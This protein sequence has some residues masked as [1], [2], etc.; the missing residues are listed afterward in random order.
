MRNIIVGTAG[1]IDH[2]KTALVRALTGEDTD[3]LAEEKRRGISIDLGFA[4]LDL[5]PDLR[6]GFVDVP[7]HERFVKNMLAGA[8][9]IDA[10][11]LVV[12]AEESI[13]PQTRE[14]FDICRLLG[15]ERGLI[16]LTKVDLAEPEMV[17]LVRLEV[18][19]FVQG[20]FLEGSPIVGVS[21]RTGEGLGDL[22]AALE[23]TAE[24]VREKDSGRHLRLPVDR[25]FVMRGFGRVVTGT[26]YSGEVRVE[27][28]LE[29]HPLGVTVRVRGIQVHGAAVDRAAAGQRTA[30]NLAGPA[31]DRV[32][33]GM[34]LTHPGRFHPSR[35]LEGRFSLLA[36]ASP[37]RHRAPI[38]L[39]LGSSEVI[40]EVRLLEPA[41]EIPPGG[42]GWVRLLLRQPL[43]VLPGDRFIARMFS[44]VTTIGGGTVLEIEPPART[45]RAQ[46]ARRL[47]TIERGSRT[48][49]VALLVKET[50]YGMGVGAL[51]RRTG[52]LIEEIRASARDERLVFFEDLA[53]W[54]ADRDSFREHA[55]RLRNALQ[56]YHDAYPLK[57]G[58]P[59]EELR[60]R[61]LAAAPA[62]Y[63]DALLQ[64]TPELV[65]DG[66]VIRLAAH[67]LSLR[68]EEETAI[69]EM[70]E[71]F[72]GAGLAVPAI[73]EVLARCGVDPR[74]AKNLL[75][76]LLRQGNLV[77]VNDELVYHQVAIEELRRLLAHHRGER[78][79]VGQF[80]DWTGVSRKYA[81]PLLEFLD[82][83]RVTRRDGDERIVL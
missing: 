34:T 45:R 26:L 7:G 75:D 29:V 66:E 47:E 57:P 70:E 46:A 41:E 44:P 83:Q 50:E 17:H 20:S 49:W 32:E 14:H 35:T 63:M 79:K 21:A 24:T 54:I 33:R 67:R 22:R 37:L 52:L 65:A 58:M 53:P 25:S 38:H 12:S 64:R 82:R 23:A 74:R 51:V 15:M 8:G 78:F 42:S 16:A 80:K 43:L 3:R 59:K 30:L 71:A 62:F 19:E 27:E 1:H 69:R 9:G 48:D 68:A 55:R 11:L 31:A 60:T 36:S 56:A 18:E 4:H 39:H 72:R 40:A 73:A 13:K 61:E 28:D 2:G 81:I 6:L 5:G 10:V 76:V 77:K